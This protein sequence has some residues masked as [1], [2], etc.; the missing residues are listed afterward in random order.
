MLNH[1][2]LF[3]YEP[4]NFRRDS[5][6]L[7]FDNFRLKC[8]RLTFQN[9]LINFMQYAISRTLFRATCENTGTDADLY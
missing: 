7:F 4:D 1:T 9:Y 6:F 5:M 3:L 2:F 8:S